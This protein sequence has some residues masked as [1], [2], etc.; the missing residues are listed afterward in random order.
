MGAERRVVV[1]RE[2]TKLHEEVVRGTA[3][4]VAERF[5]EG[6]RGEICLVIAGADPVAADPEDA[7]E[8][9]LALVAS[10]I[11]LKDAAGAVA[12]ETGVSSRELYQAALA[13]RG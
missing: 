7:L 2:L 13:S 10:G 4:E 6:A 12:A 1:C 8:R 11:R 5:A 3:V 9:V